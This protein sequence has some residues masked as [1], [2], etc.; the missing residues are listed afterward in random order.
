M[1]R[2]SLALVLTLLW[3]SPAW[4]QP[5]VEQHTNNS[6]TGL[7]SLGT[8]FSTTPDVGSLAVVLVQWVNGFTAFVTDLNVA[9]NQGNTYTRQAGQDWVG[10]GTRVYTAPIDTAS[11][12]FTITATFTGAPEWA[13]GAMRITIVEVSG[14][15]VD[16]PVE[17]ADANT[18]SSSSA[19]LSAALD[20]SADT[21]VFAV[22]GHQWDV[23]ATLASGWTE[24]QRS[25]G[26]G[27]YAHFYGDAGEDDPT[28][29]WSGSSDWTLA[30]A[31]IR[32]GS[33]EPPSSGPR[34]GLLLGVGR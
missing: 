22:A 30:A 29:S 12:T 28:V 32:A 19:A 13:T 14:A 27:G 6:G 7:L 18:G 2:L 23:T 10:R 31:G 17:D 25:T 5:E 8:S 11:G 15:D 3:V 16:D 26:T 34:R 4:A 24:F 20:I 33:A 9:D 21:V 1:R